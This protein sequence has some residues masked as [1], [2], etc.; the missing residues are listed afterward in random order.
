MRTLDI[1]QIQQWFWTWVTHEGES[2]YGMCGDTQT[3]N[4][5]VSQVPTSK[6]AHTETL[7][8]QR[9]IWEGDQELVKRSGRDESTWVTLVH[10]SNARNFSV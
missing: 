7:K 6:A 9:S 1:G 5:K 4:M 3:H 8:Q 10:G 2:T